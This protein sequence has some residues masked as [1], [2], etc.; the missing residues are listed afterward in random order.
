MMCFTVHGAFSKFCKV[1]IT[2]AI[3]D[4][5]L[6]AQT[7]LM[8]IV[9]C[10]HIGMLSATTGRLI[11]GSLL[12]CI[13]QYL[14]VRSTRHDA[15][16]PKYC[17]FAHGNKICICRAANP[18]LRLGGYFGNM[19]QKSLFF[20]GVGDDS[21]GRSV[22]T[23]F[24]AVLLIYLK[25]LCKTSKSAWFSNQPFQ[26][27]AYFLCFYY[28]SPSKCLG[29]IFSNIGGDGTKLLVGMNTTH[30]PGICGHVYM[31]NVKSMFLLWLFNTLQNRS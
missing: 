11:N 2:S 5:P 20:F 3:E 19:S 26:F 7:F 15:L 6:L 21:T 10:I 28:F 8:H 16:S 9:Q 27:L 4:W 12:S 22:S 31:W 14:A 17:K 30:P 29:D 24:S 13:Q 1:T 25:T 18:C 23:F